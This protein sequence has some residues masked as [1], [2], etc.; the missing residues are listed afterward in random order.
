M[1]SGVCNI[2]GM[3]YVEMAIPIS[4]FCYNQD[5][6]HLLSALNVSNPATR[7]LVT[8]CRPFCARMV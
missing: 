8:L 7:L 5:D 2:R 4:E 6:D 1:V 3:D